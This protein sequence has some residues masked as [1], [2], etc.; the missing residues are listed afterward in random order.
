MGISDRLLGKKNDNG[1]PHIE[2]VAPSF[3]LPG[4]EVRIVGGTSPDALLLASHAAESSATDAVA[5]I[6]GTRVLRE[7]LS[8][9]QAALSAA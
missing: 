2:A 8:A 3:A 5:L 7:P 4:G 6:P 9:A 1:K